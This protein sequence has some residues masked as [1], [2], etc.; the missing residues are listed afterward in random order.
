MYVVSQKSLVD[1]SSLLYFFAVFTLSF[2][3]DLNAL[4]YLSRDQ[5]LVPE[6]R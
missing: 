3:K 4:I 5:S 6:E 1:I 2:I